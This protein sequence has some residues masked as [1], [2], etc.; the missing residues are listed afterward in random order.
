MQHAAAPNLNV[1]IT[2]ASRG[3]GF[4]V[5]RRFAALGNH[6]IVAVAR[7]VDGLRQLKN[8]A[9]KENVQAHLYPVPFDLSSPEP[10]EQVLLPLIAGHVE[11]IDI[12]INNAGYLVHR[13]FEELAETEMVEMMQV[14][15]LAAA[16]LTRAVL[17]LM[18]QRGGHVL[19]VSSMGG[20]Q[21][22]QKFGGLAMYSAA[23][24]ALVALTECLAEEYKG[25]GI[26]FNCLALGSVD[27]EMF[28][29]AFPGMEPQHPSADMAQFI[30]D[31]AI[32]GPRFFNGKVLPVSIGTP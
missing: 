32:G 22:S 2:G 26:A 21:G 3:I 12:V 19:N 25:Q 14:N 8:A 13:P 15:F 6:N 30:A 11:N 28:R 16:R 31:F 18:R 24:A 10:Y 4:E 20:F 5:A 1:L 17:P 23:K 27:T 9:I 7:T 29:R